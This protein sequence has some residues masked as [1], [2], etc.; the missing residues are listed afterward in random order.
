MDGRAM[1]TCDIDERWNGPPPRC[2]R[3]YIFS[4]TR[5]FVYGFINV[6][7]FMYT[8]AVQCDELPDIHEN[9]RILSPNG[10]SF[11]ARAEIT[12]APGFRPNG[13]RFITCLVS[14][15]W[16]DSLSPCVQGM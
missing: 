13:A 8:L 1:L 16:S 4:L 11:G 9:A 3:N 14:G 12:C 6:M 5:K 15:Q 7:P 2:E 10:T